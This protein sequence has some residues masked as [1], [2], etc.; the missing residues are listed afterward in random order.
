MDSTKPIIVSVGGSLIVPGEI[1][2]NFLTNFK[3][4][5]IKEL[6]RGK[7]FVIITGG[8]KTARKYQQAA[9]AVTPLTTE[10]LDWLGI[11][12]TRLNAH[13]VRAIFYEYAHPEIFTHP[14]EVPGD[15]NLVV[16]AGFRP[17]SSTDLRAVEIAGNL[18]AHH[19]INLSNIDYAYTK[20]PNKFDDAEPIHETDWESFRKLLPVDWDPGLSAPFDPIAARE[21]QKLELEVVIMNGNNMEEFDNYISGEDFIGTVV[22]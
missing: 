3:Q 20:D 8:G 12:S 13:L 19:V 9:H 7:R 21:A 6:A 18:G 14:D 16:A 15:K 2:T 5:I 4:V 1:D 11:H 22:R 10:D 17:G